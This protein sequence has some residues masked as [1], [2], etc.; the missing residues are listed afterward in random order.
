[1]K[2]WLPHALAALFIYGLWGFFPKLA[3][4]SLSPASA[5]VWEVAGALAVGIA[6]LA[7]MGFRPQYDPKGVFFAVLTGI[8][9]VV[10]TLFFF[11]A[12]RTGKIAVVVSLT[13]L[14]PLIT[15]LLAVLLLGEQLGLRQMAGMALA[16][17]A[18]FLLSG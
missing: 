6:V 10:G 13:A 15:I 3:V 7:G 12:A 17:A 14:Y 9:G 4:R 2:D 16:L 5:L 1:M 18:I 11:A 8:A